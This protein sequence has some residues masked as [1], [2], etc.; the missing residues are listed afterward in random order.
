MKNMK[1]RVV[2]GVGVAVLAA[3]GVYVFSGSKSARADFD[4]SALATVERETMVKSVVATGKVEPIT[5][6]EIKSKANGIIEALRVDVGHIVNPGDILVEL[7][8]ENLSARVREERANLQAAEASLTGAEAALQKNI[9]E[10]EGPDVEFARR[11]HARASKLFEQQLIAAVRPRRSE[12][13]A[14]SRREPPAQRQEPAGGRAREG[15]GSRGQGRAGARAGLAHRGGAAERDDPRAHPRHGADA[16][17]RNRQP[18]LVDPQH[19]LRRDAGDDARRHPGSLR[20]RQG[21]RSRHRPRP[22]RAGR[23]AS[24]SRPSRT[25]SSRARSRRSRRSA[26]RRTTSPRSRWRSRSR[27]RATS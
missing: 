8:K 22:P 11:A 26:S 19:G 27:T 2:Y 25:R 14:R 18:G 13:R 21:R 10:A 12:E 6:V 1:R 5:K 17:R 16:R 4:P 15:G 3:A 23:R 7:D 24:A 9:V 20:P